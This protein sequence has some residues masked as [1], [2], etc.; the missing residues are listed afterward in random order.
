MASLYGSYS[1]YRNDH[2]S[3]VVGGDIVSKSIGSNCSKCGKGRMKQLL[4]QTIE[5]G[6]LSGFM[7]PPEVRGKKAVIYKCNACGY[8]EVYLK[9]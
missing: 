5:A 2:W 9:D 8:I 6:I 4:V 7:I 3:Q 1:I